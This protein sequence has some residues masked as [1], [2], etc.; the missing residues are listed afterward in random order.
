M[1]I[2]MA[3]FL[4]VLCKG[5]CNSAVVV[6]TLTMLSGSL[7]TRLVIRCSVVDFST[8]DVQS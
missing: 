6:Y 1:F 8:P 4:A 2:A 3:W 7:S 5:F